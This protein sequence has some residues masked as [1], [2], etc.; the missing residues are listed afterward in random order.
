LNDLG[1]AARC[2]IASAHAA[3]IDTQ[4]QTLDDCR[5]PATHPNQELNVA[6]VL[7]ID[8]RP[9]GKVVDDLRR[10]GVATDELLKEVGL[11]RA[12][13][14]DP[15]ARIPYAAYVGLIERAASLLGDASYGL[16]LGASQDARDSG[17]LGFIVLN[18]PT[19]MD[20]VAN[21]HRYFHVIG[22]GVDIEFERSGPHVALRFRETDQALRGLR[23]NSEYMAAIV[24]RGCRD[25]TRK[26][27][28]PVRA[29]FMH[30][31]PNQKVDYESYLGCPVK[32]HAEWDAVIYA[33]E[34]MQLLVIEADN[35]LLRVLKDACQKILGP[36]PKKK[37]LVH[38]VREL[39]IQ[40]LAKGPAHFDDI[41]RDV[42]MSSKTL[43]RRLAERG[44]SFRVLLDDI[45][46]D[47]TK[48][49]LG[50]T[51]FR[52]EQVAYLVGYSEPAALVRAF[53]RWTGTT[54][55]QFRQQHH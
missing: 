13:V 47:L 26:R 20:A 3:C 32:F 10:H 49:Y 41:A 39:V 16:R 42:N 48:R 17:M 4:R 46:R 23:H 52:L 53:R 19:L 8:A 33:A 1:C 28:S 54:P 37:D 7:K 29:E 24:V 40:R 12:D 43:E 51:D 11:R 15:E 21:L 35:K 38:D 30:G 2:E 9:A 50:E 44:K 5:Q 25:M 6:K 31:R 22:E 45:R 14:A 18:S 27:I 55:I 36:T 34:T